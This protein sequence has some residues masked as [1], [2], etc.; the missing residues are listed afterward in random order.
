[1]TSL[2]RLATIELQLVLHLCDVHS[3]LAL[4]RCSRA[5]LHAASAP[6][7]QRHLPP[8][9]FRFQHPWPAGGTD[10]PKHGRPAPARSLAD[11]LQ[12]SLLRHCVLSIVWH[13]PAISSLPLARDAL[14]ALLALVHVQQLKLS[15]SVDWR[16]LKPPPA[17]VQAL[18]KLTLPAQAIA[19]GSEVLLPVLVQ[20]A[21]L[22]HTV[23]IEP[24]GSS[25]HTAVTCSDAQVGRL[26][27]LP[28]L[29]DLRL[30]CPTEGSS[31]VS[32]C[33]KL[34]RLELT[35]VRFDSLVTTLSSPSLQSL[36]WLTLHDCVHQRADRMQ[37]QAH[38]AEREQLCAMLANLPHLRTLVLLRV[39]FASLLV[40]AL[41]QQPHA[42][43]LKLSLQVQAFHF[44]QADGLTVSWLRALLHSAPAT[45]RVQLY[46]HGS[47]PRRP[48]SAGPSAVA[49]AGPDE[50]AALRLLSRVEECRALA[51]DE[52]QRFAF[53][54]GAQAKPA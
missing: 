42:Q 11:R 31:S 4:A 25:V 48:S 50:T 2:S 7:S 41:A 35:N 19:G 38:T 23:C 40:E 18:Q 44:G 37:P 54:T 36:R 29:T 13:A 30:H 9:H 27:A 39:S 14:A 47:F 15:G 22:L 46:V 21:P 51:L 53:S 20:H 43:L 24:S 1:M 16:H 5:T 32:E 33:S 26:Y 28:A 8:L 12:R 6:F 52:P 45:L 3:W 34:S 49:L 10:K 17:F